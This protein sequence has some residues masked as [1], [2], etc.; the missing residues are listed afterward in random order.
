MSTLTPIILAAG[1]STRMGRPKALLDFDGKTALELALDAVA[2][3]GRPVVVL[4]PNHEEIEA[5][6][7]LRGR[8]VRGALNLDVPS[9]QTASLLRGLSVLPA[10]AEAFLF[11]PVDFPL[12]SAADVER[13]VEAYRADRDA[14]AAIFIPSHGMK[15]GHPVLCRRELAAELQALPAGAPA[16]EVIHRDPGRIA[17]VEYPEAYVLMDMDTPEDYVRCLGAYRARNARSR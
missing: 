8:S 4:G 17:Y 15:R 12:V 10:N 2:G 6:V 11:M 1:A 5:A 9:G 13:L 14:R 3:V 7:D 16:R